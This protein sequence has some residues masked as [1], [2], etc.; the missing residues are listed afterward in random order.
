MKNNE[1]RAIYD[2]FANGTL[3]RKFANELTLEEEA[4][5]RFYTNKSYWFGGIC[6]GLPYFGSQKSH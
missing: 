1:F 2:D 6:D 4:I 5:L 3:V